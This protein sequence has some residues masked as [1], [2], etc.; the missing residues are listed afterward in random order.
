MTRPNQVLSLSR[1]VGTGRR[2][3]W[4]RGCASLRVTFSVT[5]TVSQSKGS[6]AFCKLV[7]HVHVLRQENR[8]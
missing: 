7:L 3:P 4:E 8:T 6:T 2:E 1:S 5:V